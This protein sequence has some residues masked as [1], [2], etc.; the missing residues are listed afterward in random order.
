M[1]ENLKT[2]HSCLGTI[3][4]LGFSL[5]NKEE[6]KR[7]EYAVP[8]EELLKAW[9]IVMMSQRMTPSGNWEGENEMT[10][11]KGF[12]RYNACETFHLRMNGLEMPITG[13]EIKQRDKGGGK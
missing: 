3:E 8:E 5:E 6:L 10:S 2:V 13:M 7:L 1:K 11:K 9:M 12:L 4:V